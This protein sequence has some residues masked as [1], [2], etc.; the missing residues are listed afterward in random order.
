[1]TMGMRHMLGGLL[2]RSPSTNGTGAVLVAE[3][4]PIPLPGPWS[5]GVALGMHSEEGEGTERSEIGELLARFEYAGQRSLGRMLGEALA[6]AVAPWRPEVVVHIPSSRRHAFEPA[7]EL[8]RATARALRVRCLPRFIALTRAVQPQ[9][10]LT[11]LSEKKENVRGAFKVRRAE[12]IR[13]RR[14]LIVDDVYDSG[15]TLEEAW[16]VV[17]EAGAADITVAAVTKTRYQRDDPS[18]GSG[19]PRA[20]FRTPKGPF[21]VPEGQSRGDR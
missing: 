12:L 9:K 14:V 7:C 6:K 10:D 13:G 16:R 2:H 1:L 15:A 18:A 8:A 11:S 5:Y 19:S 20:P 21:R 3:L 17:D 4:E